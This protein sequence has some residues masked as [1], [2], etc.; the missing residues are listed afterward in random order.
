MVRFTEEESSGQKNH[1]FSGSTVAIQ[2]LLRVYIAFVYQ[3]HRQDLK[4]KSGPKITEF[5]KKEKNIPNKM[6]QKLCKSDKK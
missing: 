1:S 3:E 6:V 4:M 2:H 5:N